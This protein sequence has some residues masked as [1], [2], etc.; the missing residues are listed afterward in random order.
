VSPFFTIGTGIIQIEPKATLVQ[1]LDRRD[2]TAY[3]GGGL[4]F[5]LG[6]RF[7][8]RG[9]YKSHMLF[10]SRDENEEIDEWKIG[11]AFFF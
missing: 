2:Q 4:R 3:V 6:R 8:I 5:Y 9:E 7:F 10:T 1:P 11:L